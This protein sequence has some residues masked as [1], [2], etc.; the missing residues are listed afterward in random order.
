ML[1]DINRSEDINYI[2][3]ACKHFMTITEHKL[4]VMDLCFKVGL[5]KQAFLHDLSKYSPEEF[6]CG[7]MYYQGVRSPNAAQR[8][9]KGYSSAWLHHKGRNKHHFEYWIDY[10]LTRGEGLV[11]MKMPLKY[12]LEMVCDRIAAS[13]V[14]NKGNYTTDIPWEY[15]NKGPIPDKDMH[16]E[17]RALLEKLLL[18]NKEK[19]EKK[20]LAYMRWLLKHPYI[21]EKTD[22]K[23]IPEVKKL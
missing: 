23:I 21:Y 22:L 1:N 5:V 18:M 20:L 13:K 12:V 7:I 10:S 15:Y 2:K 9:E 6:I 19:G 11:G 14:Y 16:K 17:T 4:T 8:L 3:N